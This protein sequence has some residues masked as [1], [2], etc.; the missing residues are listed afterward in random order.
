ML[1]NIK[2]HNVEEQYK[3][4]A[5]IFCLIG[6]WETETHIMLRL[7][8]NLVP[9]TSASQ[10]FW[11]TD[12]SNHVWHQS[13]FLFVLVMRV[14]PCTPLSYLPNTSKKAFQ[15][16]S[17]KFELRTFMGVFCVFSFKK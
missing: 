15:K 8:S 6:F 7:A 4:Q 9:T 16:Y 5:S 13:K 12:V 11:V 17:H 14:K 3:D 2:I 1:G 10:L